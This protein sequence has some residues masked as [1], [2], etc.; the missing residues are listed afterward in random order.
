MS[1]RIAAPSLGGTS[2]TLSKRPALECSRLSSTSVLDWTITGLSKASAIPSVDCPEINLKLADGKRVPRGN[3]APGDHRFE[4]SEDVC[5]RIEDES[6][7]A[8]DGFEFGTVALNVDWLW[9]IS[10]ADRTVTRSARSS[11]GVTKPRSTRSSES[12]LKKSRARLINP[13]L[14]SSGSMSV[15]TR[16]I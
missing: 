3:G 13:V 7:E 11:S 8:L 12:A 10:P 4:V 6:R 14:T 9:V 5:L 15:E 1:F 16:L 2:S